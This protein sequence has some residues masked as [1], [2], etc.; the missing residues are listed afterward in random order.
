MS[1]ITNSPL[2]P[3]RSNRPRFHA[4]PPGGRRTHNPSRLSTSKQVRLLAALAAF[5]ASAIAAP[6]NATAQS[7]PAPLSPA[8]CSNG[9]YVGD[10]GNNP[11][12]VAD[13]TALVA[14]RNHFMSNPANA[15]LDWAS[16]WKVTDRI[17]IGGGRVL[18]SESLRPL[19]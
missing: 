5:A 4:P 13:C 2:M 12:L 1:F 10:P 3:V 16:P 19:R 9:T 6:V 17:F 7:A 11:G 14:I 15:G 18:F 8:D